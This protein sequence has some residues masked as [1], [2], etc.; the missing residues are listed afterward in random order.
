MNLGTIKR[1]IRVI[2][3]DTDKL[4]PP[5]WGGPKRIWNLY[6]NLPQDKFNIH[7]VGCD[8]SRVE[9]KINK[10]APNF[11]EFLIP[12]PRHYIKLWSP[13]NKKYFQSL[14]FDAFVY[15]MMSS[16]KE[17]GNALRKLK[18]DVLISSH[19]WSAPSMRKKKEQLF[20]YDAHNCEYSL[21]KAL[22]KEHPLCGL[23]S[24]WVKNIESAACKKSDIIL[25][26]STQ[27]KNEFIKLYGVKEEKI[28]I[29]PNGAVPRAINTSGDKA[30][31]KEQLGLKGRKTAVF[32]GSY[33]E[34]NIRAA[35][36]IIDKLA[37][38]LKEYDFLIG[39]ASL[40]IVFSSMNLPEN[41]RFYGTLSAEKLDLIM[42]AA[43]IALNPVLM[44]SGINIKMLDY[45]SYGLPVVST[46]CGARGI[47]INGKMPLIISTPPEFAYN[48]RILDNDRARYV[49]MSEDARSLASGQYSWKII[50][51][52][53]EKL[54]LNML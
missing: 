48:I 46:E 35:H 36:F 6:S 19:P 37:P 38:D 53:L 26:C 9:L 41:V 24:L 23:I 40:E 15:L 52:G 14:R 16:V 30:V 22:I 51:S 11:R 20:I 17:F 25:V 13:L 44:G 3:S 42:K 47:N 4:N 29:V 39:G 33:Y 45:M 43:D 2:V 5:I 50:S 18:A 28:H 21:T 49:K 54:I 32:I 7:Y 31:A 10:L 8:F 27:E 1:K 34:P 12:C